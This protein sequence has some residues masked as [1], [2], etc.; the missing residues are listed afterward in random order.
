M[1]GHRHGF[2]GSN[3]TKR[4]SPH[5]KILGTTTVGERG[6]V[7]IPAEARAEMDISSGDKLVV[8]GNCHNGSI[9]LVKAEI[10]DRYAEFFLSKSKKL[11]K[12]AEEIL[13]ATG[14]DNDHDEEKEGKAEDQ[15][16]AVFHQ[17]AEDTEDSPE[18]PAPNIAS[19]KDFTEAKRKKLGSDDA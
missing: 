16:E 2:T 4:T 5:G 11:E 6:Q 17:A 19:D 14:D 3:K 15:E 10:F 13:R 8:F 9:T 18:R 1:H 7:V 12:I